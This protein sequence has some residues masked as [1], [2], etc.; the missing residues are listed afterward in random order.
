LFIGCVS[1]RRTSFWSLASSAF[2]GIQVACHHCHEDILSVLVGACGSRGMLQARHRFRGASGVCGAPLA[3]QF[4][5]FVGG[6]YPPSQSFLSS[7]APRA[8]APP[9]VA[10]GSRPVVRGREGLYSTPCLKGGHGGPANSRG[11]LRS[12]PSVKKGS[13]PFTRGAEGSG[14][15]SVALAAIPGTPH[16]AAV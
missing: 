6:P 2:P 16:H 8:R 10:K 9:S 4:T 12:L 14:S 5:R 13:R 7:F 11:R 15:P 3:R 1:Y